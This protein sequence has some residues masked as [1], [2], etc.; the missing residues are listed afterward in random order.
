MIQLS[1]INLLNDS[2]DFT[3]ECASKGLAY[4]YEIGKNNK[5]LNNK[6]INSLMLPLPKR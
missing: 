4:C 3:I 1:F 5:E 6:L 2:K